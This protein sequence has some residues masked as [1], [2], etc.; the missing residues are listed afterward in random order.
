MKTH[1]NPPEMKY[2]Q[3]LQFAPT[4]AESYFRKLQ[5]CNKKK[6]KKT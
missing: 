6:Y 2:L 1:H 3:E 4:H 5:I